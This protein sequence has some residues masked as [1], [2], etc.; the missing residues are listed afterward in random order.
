[1]LNL[2]IGFT[3]QYLNDNVKCFDTTMLLS[4][5]VACTNQKV[6]HLIK[7]VVYM[8]YSGQTDIYKYIHALTYAIYIIIYI[9]ITRNITCCVIG[10]AQSRI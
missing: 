6:P 3:T 2:L 8:C 7:T 4:S 5:S 10:I 9:V 1:M